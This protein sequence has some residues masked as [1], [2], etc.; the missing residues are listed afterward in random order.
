MAAEDLITLAEAR[1]AL[2]LPAGSTS[3]DAD[4]ASTYIP[5]VTP[6]VEDVTGPVVRRPFTHTTAGGS[7]AVLLPRAASSITSVTARGVALAADRYTADLAA[8]VVYAG[9]PLT[10]GVFDGGVGDVVVAYVAGLC[11]DTAS[12]PVNIKL[13]ARLVL[14]WSWQNDQQGRNPDAAAAGPELV[15]TP[16]GFWIPAAAYAYL[17]PSDATMPGFA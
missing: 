14:A 7:R 15:Q 12:V 16:S 9:G 10:P 3:R 8:G 6:L 5:A 4:I 2:R 11:A 1:N 17:K 13:G